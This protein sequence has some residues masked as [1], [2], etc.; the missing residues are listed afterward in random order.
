VVT[1]EK[2]AEA[3]EEAV[4]VEAAEVDSVAEVV[5]EVDS[6]KNGPH[7]PNSEDSS[8]PDTSHLLKKFTLTPSQSR[9]HQSLTD[10]SL[11]SNT[12]FPMK[13]C[14]FSPSKSKP[15]P[16]KEPDSRLLLPLVTDKVTLVLVLRLLR[17]SKLLLRV[18]S[19]MPRLTLFQ[20]EE[21]IGV[22]ESVESIPSQLR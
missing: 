10:L 22:P 13:L 7:L 18:L 14:A 5:A 12:N 8:K 16:V 21:V 15:R 2:V 3:E 9:K 1:E 4:E 11:T 6:R 17:K 19:L 20:S